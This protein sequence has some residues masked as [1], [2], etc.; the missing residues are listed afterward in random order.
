MSVSARRNLVV[1]LFLLPFFLLFVTFTA[2]PFLWALWL[3]MHKGLLTGPKVFC[4]FDNFMAL[5]RDTITQT[6][7]MNTAKY[8]CLVVP[9]EVLSGLAVAFLITNKFVR[10]RDLFR[11]IAY[12]PILASPAA[13]A[14][15]WSYILAPR[16]GI[17]SYMLSLI[18]V[19]DIYFL[20]NP[21]IALLSVALV[22]WWRSLGFYT[23]LFIASLVGIPRELKE[24]ASIDGA[25][26]WQVA[27][28]VT[29][30]LMRPVILFAVVMSTI[31]AFQLFDTVFVLTNGGPMNSTA[32]IVWYI[33]N[34][35]FRYSQVGLAAAMGV[36]LLLII[37]PISFIQ[38]QILGREV[39]YA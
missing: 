7:L 33:Y 3:S 31:W 21:R 13:A 10:G 25:S 29:I 15:I 35:A 22:V 20:S 12:F 36:V 30:P 37:A 5:P 4:H 38:M 24:A 11:A 14:Q 2:I 28:K 27:T 17:I 39:E 16:F 6:V 34:H 26:P 9:I 32:T 23:V 1:Y 18:G 19:R 8:V